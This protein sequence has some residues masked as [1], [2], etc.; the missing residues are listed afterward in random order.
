MELL[1]PPYFIIIGLNGLF[2][3]LLSFWSSPICLFWWKNQLAIIP[4]L[5]SMILKIFVYMKS[6]FGQPIGGSTSAGC[7]SFILLCACKYAHYSP[8]EEDRPFY[9]TYRFHA[10]YFILVLSPSHIL[11]SEE[12]VFPWFSPLLWRAFHVNLVSNLLLLLGILFYYGHE[13]CIS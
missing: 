7:W 10:C 11:Y 6:V 13:K 8:K 1:P 4:I 5:G 3:L 2:R 9:Y 12:S